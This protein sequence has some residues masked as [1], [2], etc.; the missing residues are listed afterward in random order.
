M[1][2]LSIWEKDLVFRLMC[3]AGS[4]IVSS[5]H[6]LDIAICRSFSVVLGA[7]CA[8]C[9]LLCQRAQI[10]ECFW[11]QLRAGKDFVLIAFALGSGAR[12]KLSSRVATALMH[13]RQIRT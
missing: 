13:T 5:V 9:S 7:G 8:A 4:T 1:L 10:A 3:R 2:Y 12:S 6:M 11:K